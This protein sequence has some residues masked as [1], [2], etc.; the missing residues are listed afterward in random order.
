[1]RS[2]Q[3]I[4]EYDFE[5]LIEIERFRSKYNE[6]LTLDVKNLVKARID[7]SHEILEGNIDIIISLA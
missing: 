5:T 7:K 4:N 1:M 6:A 2:Q 3:L